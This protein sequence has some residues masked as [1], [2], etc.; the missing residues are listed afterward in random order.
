[1]MVNKQKMMDVY[2]E[3]LIMYSLLEIENLKRRRNELLWLGGFFFSMA[4]P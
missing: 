4:K 1:M 3:M 2:R